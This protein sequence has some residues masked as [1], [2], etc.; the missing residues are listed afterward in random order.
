MPLKVSCESL[1]P[2]D[3]FL[4]ERHQQLAFG[5]ELERLHVAAIGDPDIAG[6]IDAQKM[7]GLEHALAPR[8]QEFPVPIEGHDRHRLVAAEARTRCRARPRPRRWPPPI[9]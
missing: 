1:P 8:P 7:G 6:T 2:S 3:A 4:A 5:V 9:S